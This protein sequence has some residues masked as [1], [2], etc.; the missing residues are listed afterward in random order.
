MR[1]K[2]IKQMQTNTEKYK[3][4]KHIPFKNTILKGKFNINKVEL[5]K[6]RRLNYSLKIFQS[7]KVIKI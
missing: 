6:K 2:K 4:Q 7:H 5:S 1:I 3:T